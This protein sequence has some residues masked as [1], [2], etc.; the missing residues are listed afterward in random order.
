MPATATS[1]A[2][3]SSP[4]T[5]HDG[6]MDQHAV[7]VRV[8]GLVQGVFYRARCAEEAERLGVAG[9]VSNEPDGSVAGHFEGPPEAVDALV[10]WCREGSPRASVDRVE[11][12][13]VPAEGVTGFDAR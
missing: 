2:S 1:C 9:W 8:T 13:E 7:D 6:R 5:R 12:T 4:P 10:A 11:V 3:R